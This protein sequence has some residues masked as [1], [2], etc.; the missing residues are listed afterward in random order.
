MRRFS[1][2]TAVLVAAW[3]VAVSPVLAQAPVK[4][5]RDAPA[6]EPQLVLF[7]GT[8][9]EVKGAS[10]IPGEK[11]TVTAFSVRRGSVT[12]RF[13]VKLTGTPASPK[14][15]ILRGLDELP[16]S[17]VTD[18]LKSP[19]RHVI[20]THTASV[21]PGTDALPATR[22]VLGF[23]E[24]V[25]GTVSLAELAAID[26]VVGTGAV[27]GADS[28]VT[29]NY[30]GWLADGTMVDSSFGRGAFVVKLGRGDVIKAWELGIP[31]MR[32]GGRRRLLVPSRL[33]YG[34][35]G[36]GRSIPSNAVLVF[37]I[38]LIAVREKW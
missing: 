27:A 28:I 37:D 6:V 23:L 26:R 1:R 15:A 3:F 12:K 17:K 13:A 38:E 21:V 16:A 31:G 2:F 4:A 25:G 22:V 10:S 18:A 20:V 35:Q 19:G 9:V 34:V 7:E 33:G 36:S 24:L 8:I 5:R 30:I 11:G 29:V 14:T 32:V